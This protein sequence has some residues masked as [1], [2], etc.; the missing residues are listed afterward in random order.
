M[1]EQG[2]T[3]IVSE[4]C[5]ERRSP[6]RVYLARW[7]RCSFRELLAK[8][9]L[10]VPLL[11]FLSIV[12][13]GF[14]LGDGGFVNTEG[15]RTFPA[16]EMLADGDYFTQ[17]L[18]G[19][20]YLRKP[21]GHTW[22]IAAS[23]AMFGK[24]EFAARFVGAVS[25][26]GM[27]LVTYWFARRWFGA[28]A[29]LPA[30]I[31]QML[32]PLFWKY[33][34]SAE[35]EG[36]HNFLVQLMVLLLIELFVFQRNKASGR[37]TLFVL[38]CGWA[39]SGTVLV[40][41]PASIPCF[42]GTLVAICLVER[43]REPLRS[44]TLWSVIG[45]CGALIIPVTLLILHRTMTA[46]EPVITQRVLGFFWETSL[47][48]VL[49]MIPS[50]WLQAF[51]LC[52]FLIAPWLRVEQ[53]ESRSLENRLARVLAA[54]S[55][56]SV[57]FYATYGLTNPRYA[58]PAVTFV[59]P[60][61]GY[62]V[63]IR[64]PFSF[65]FDPTGVMLSSWGPRAATFV[66]V[67]SWV[68]YIEYFEPRARSKSGEQEG[69]RLAE[70]LPD[71]AEIWADTLIEARPETLGYAREFATR[72][73]KRIEVQWKPLPSN[74]HPSPPPQGMFV[75]LRTDNQEWEYWKN[76][77]LFD[78]IDWQTE[79]KVYKYHYLIGKVLDPIPQ[80]ARSQR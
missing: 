54:S 43:T 58:M 44:K 7:L 69:R 29:G 50:A 45:I 64:R 73:G 25:G 15:H 34:R 62:F 17:R 1:S 33:Q 78:Q 52:L 67:A 3:S 22:A 37:H 65:R 19:V 75:A 6:T 39:A 2:E 77:R 11:L 55:L 9:S 30:G 24:T 72:L 14:R 53:T 74:H 49:T 27:V 20:I 4:R 31:A 12:V 40:K 71:G 79:G 35:I 18:F 60:L 5:S 61:V 16:W 36:L 76:A 57:F 21:L 59:S 47:V 42:L 56:L 13:Y 46:N 70:V 68:G 80:T 66:L 26:I 51:P 48:G 63:T 28:G 41:G 38:C 8:P 23:S 32:T 10:Q